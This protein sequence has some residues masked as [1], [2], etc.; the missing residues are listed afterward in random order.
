MTGALHPELT[1]TIAHLWDGGDDGNPQA[2]FQM[3]TAI[4]NRDVVAQLYVKMA[5]PLGTTLTRMHA[6][7]PTPTPPKRAASSRRRVW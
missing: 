2:L 1:N 6:C 5:P 7:V 4:D 3:I